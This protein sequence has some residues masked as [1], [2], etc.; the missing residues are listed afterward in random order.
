MSDD[1][2]RQ[3]VERG[4]VVIVPGFEDHLCLP[5]ADLREAFRLRNL[6]RKQRHLRGFYN[7]HNLLSEAQDARGEMLRLLRAARSSWRIALGL[8]ARVLKSP[9][10]DHEACPRRPATHETHSTKPASD[11]SAAAGS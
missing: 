9:A 8:E 3:A 10:V 5:A 6:A 11:G 7:E 4:A 1:D 2:H